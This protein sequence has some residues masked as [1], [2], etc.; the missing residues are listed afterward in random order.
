MI[1]N[2]FILFFRY[3]WTLKA[4]PFVLADTD[5][6]VHFYIPVVFILKIDI[7]LHSTER[8]TSP[9]YPSTKRRENSEIVHPSQCLSS[10]VTTPGEV[11]HLWGPGQDHIQGKEE[12]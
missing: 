3:S 1:K 2:I 5:K 9:T 7:A 12:V 6:I 4:A 11:C 10:A 8:V